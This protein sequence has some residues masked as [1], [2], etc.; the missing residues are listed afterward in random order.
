MVNNLE[1]EV[2]EKKK[3]GTLF[4]NDISGQSG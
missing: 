4:T 2:Q 3:S 1:P